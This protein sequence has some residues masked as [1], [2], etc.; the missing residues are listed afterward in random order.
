MEPPEFPESTLLMTRA[1]ALPVVAIT[2]IVCAGV[3]LFG[4][5]SRGPRRRPAAIE[6]SR[7]PQAGTGGRET[8]DIIEGIVTGAQPGQQIVL[9]AKSGR[10]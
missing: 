2:A 7:I 9:F 6:F 8:Q 3:C 4:G 1:F 5:C 10:W